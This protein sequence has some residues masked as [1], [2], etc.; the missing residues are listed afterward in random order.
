ML[1]VHK[2]KKIEIYLKLEKLGF[3]V[4]T[5]VAGMKSNIFKMVTKTVKNTKNEKLFT[6]IEEQTLIS[7]KINFLSL[8][9]P[10]TVNNKKTKLIMVTIP[11][12]SLE[13]IFKI[14]TI[15]DVTD[16]KIP[17]YKTSSE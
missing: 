4:V 10:Y 2:I 6:K 5:K 9:T 7:A 8:N 17:M 13:F 11:I 16:K 3:V 1:D 15:Y 14:A 12:L